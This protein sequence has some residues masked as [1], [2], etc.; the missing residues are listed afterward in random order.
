MQ[1]VF[2]TV[3]MIILFFVV[4]GLCDELNINTIFFFLFGIGLNLIKCHH[5][6]H[7]E[8]ET[9]NRSKL[10]KFHTH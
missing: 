7:I 9:F 3:I 5:Q 8:I 2:L 6:K 4:Y 1:V 10:N